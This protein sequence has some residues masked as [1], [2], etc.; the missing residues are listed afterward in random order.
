MKDIVI[1]DLD[2]TLANHEHRLHLIDKAPKD[3]DEFIEESKNDKLNLPVVG[4][5]YSVGDSNW[6][7]FEVAIVTARPER[8]RDITVEW[9]QRN[10]LYP[11]AL[12]MR[13]NND[14]R[15]DWEVKEDIL[16]NNI[17]RQRVLFAVEDRKCCVDM[18]RR[19]GVFCFDV[20]GGE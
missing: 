12:L 16:L 8:H 10:R 7:N 20:R 19:N 6:P 3:W 18:Y 1:F 9:L 2:G 13:D 11:H 17:G 14:F 4:F 5:F 15:P